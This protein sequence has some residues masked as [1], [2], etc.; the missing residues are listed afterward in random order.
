[1]NIRK[2]KFLVLLVSLTLF[3]I[4]LMSKTG[5]FRL[6]WKNAPSTSIIIGWDQISG[7]DGKVFFDTSPKGKFP[8]KYGFSKNPDNIVP[9]K[10]MNNHFVRLE[11]LLPNTVY[12]FVVADSEGSSDVYSFQTAPNNSNSRLSIIAG[13]DSRN[14][15]NA[16]KNANK[17]VGKLRPHCVMFGGDFTDNDTDNEWKNWFDDWQ[18]TISSDGRM[19]PII[20]AR[21]NHEFSNKTLV[22]LFDLQVNGLHYAMSL[23]GNLLR[24]YTLNSMIAP[25]GQQRLW[26]QGDLQKH[27]NSI[28]KTAQH[29]LSTRPHVA[30]KKEN[31][32]QWGHWSKLFYEFGVDFVVESDAHSV[33]STYPLRPETGAGSDEGFIRD[34]VNGTIYIG[35]GCWGAPVRPNND[36]KE[37]TRAS[38]SFNSFH[39][40]FVDKDKIE[41]RFIKT[42]NAD[43]V[44]EN[45]PNDIFSF[46]RGLNIWVP[47]NGTGDVI[48]ISAIKSIQAAPQ[49]VASGGLKS[50]QD[51]VKGMSVPSF[52]VSRKGDDVHVNWST[53]GEVEGYSFKL[54][55]AINNAAHKPIKMISGMGVG[56][57]NYS[58]TDSGFAKF[59]PS[60]Q[61]D[62]RLIPIAPT[63]AQ[64]PP[65]IK[66]PAPVMAAR[67][68]TKKEVKKPG[69]MSKIMVDKKTKKAMISFN[70]PREGH[71]KA[72]LFSTPSKKEM[73]SWSIPCDK[74]GKLVRPIECI[75]INKGKYI[76]V[77]YDDGKPLEKYSLIVP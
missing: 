48:E 65:A 41:I 25:G 75:G 33:K 34:D 29:H 47:D 52:D 7:K 76:L 63:P 9:Y 77:V 10:G 6:V 61:V 68:D 64:S 17:L 22:N 28:W 4:D 35:E 19:Y 50:T 23:G 14:H 73:R 72:R 69:G 38:G 56:S 26:L 60:S 37:W 11:G 51:I 67:G 70:S 74:V 12:Y 2:H 21:G 49:L 13:S 44:A 1:M 42:D 36:T 20:A 58:F 55:R 62:Y 59:N 40:I 24:I 15:R 46:P 30:L 3:S 27:S 66:E 53:K 71:V 8:T 43:K 18:S 39:W 54:T 16:R 31:N 45:R 32:D 57:H 5:R